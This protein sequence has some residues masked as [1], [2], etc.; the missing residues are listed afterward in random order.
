MQVQA[1]YKQEKCYHDLPVIYKK[2]GK[3]ESLFPQAETRQLTHHSIEEPCQAASLAPRAYRSVAGTYVAATPQVQEVPPPR[4]SSTT[5][6][7]ALQVDREHLDFSGSTSGNLY[8]EK[9]LQGWQHLQSWPDY[10]RAHQAAEENHREVMATAGSVSYQHL[11]LQAMTNPLKMAIGSI[12]NFL[13]NHILQLGS[14]CGLVLMAGCVGFLCCSCCTSGLNLKTDQGCL[15]MTM[16]LV[17]STLC[18][19]IYLLHQVGLTR[20]ESPA[21]RRQ[22]AEEMVMMAKKPRAPDRPEASAQAA[23]AELLTQPARKKR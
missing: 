9:Q 20:K 11:G 16:N 4:L 5:K 13:G 14:I 23:L 17:F 6:G 1:D 12:K 2:D 19:P 8:T 21:A 3:Q 7:W 10:L 18:L 22:T 15:K